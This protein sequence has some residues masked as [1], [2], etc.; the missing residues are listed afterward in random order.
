[1]DES[2]RNLLREINQTWNSTYY[3]VQEQA[4]LTDG[5]TGEYGDFLKAA[6]YWQGRV[7]S[8]SYKMLEVFYILILVVVC[9]YI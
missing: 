7:T 9:G 2:H 1:M 3:I 6:G 8:E 5:N 4:K